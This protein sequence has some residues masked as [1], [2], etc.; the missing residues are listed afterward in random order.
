MGR[1]EKMFLTK[2]M[3]ARRLNR[4]EQIEQGTELTES[5]LKNRGSIFC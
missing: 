3:G 4:A 1:A 2:K 5:Q